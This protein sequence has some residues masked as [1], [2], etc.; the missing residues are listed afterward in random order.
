MGPRSEEFPLAA[1][2]GGGGISTQAS[3]VGVIVGYRYSH[4]DG[5]GSSIVVLG[6]GGGG[7]SLMPAVTVV[8]AGAAVRMCTT[9]PVTTMGGGALEGVDLRL[10]YNNASRMSTTTRT[11]A[12]PPK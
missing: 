6:G 9:G 3:G 7:N 11:V 5:A 10:A 12:I 2:S 4:C 8:T 1:H